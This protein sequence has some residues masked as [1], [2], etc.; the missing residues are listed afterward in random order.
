ML[1]RRAEPARLVGRT[2]RAAPRRQAAAR[3]DTGSRRRPIG[4][5][6]PQ[7]MPETIERPGRRQ[8][9]GVPRHDRLRRVPGRAATGLVGRHGGAGGS[10]ADTGGHPDRDRQA[11]AD[12]A[13]CAPLG[14]ALDALSAV[15]PSTTSKS[16]G[17]PRPAWVE[18]GIRRI[19]AGRDRGVQWR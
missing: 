18:Q 14:R 6:W 16:S 1:M 15:S 13:S 19:N 12:M 17:I 10:G 8:A 4:R 11:R 2:S 7:V 5:R 3:R 9:D